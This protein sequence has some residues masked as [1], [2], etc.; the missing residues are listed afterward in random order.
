MC[1]FICTF[2]FMSPPEI[3]SWIILSLSLH[4]NKTV[5]HVLVN[6]MIVSLI[7]SHTA[8][9]ASLYFWLHYKPDMISHF[10]PL[11]LSSQKWRQEICCVITNWRENVHH[12][13]SLLI[14]YFPIRFYIL[15]SFYGNIFSPS[16]LSWK[17]LWIWWYI[18]NFLKIKSILNLKC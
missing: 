4:Y 3:F 11:F 18:W 17:V 12:G 2:Y 10:F 15:V 13:I 1:T 8:V 16:C 6:K 5:W 14:Q 7:I 9:C